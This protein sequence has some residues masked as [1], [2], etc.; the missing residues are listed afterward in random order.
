MGF[1]LTECLCTTCV[2]FPQKTKEGLISA[3]IGGTYH[4]SSTRKTLFF[5]FDR[6]SLCSPGFSGTHF[7]D[8]ASLC[9]LSTET[10]NENHHAWLGKHILYNTPG[11]S[12]FMAADPNFYYLNSLRGVCVYV[13][14][15]V[16]VYLCLCLCMYVFKLF[17]Q[18][19]CGKIKLESLF[20]D[21]FR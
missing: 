11:C 13:C 6:V 9:L 15:C 18:S 19:D 21:F 14:V 5:S 4:I 10:K 2:Q 1:V 8:Q 12:P 17:N 20:S 16:C 7:V 3:W